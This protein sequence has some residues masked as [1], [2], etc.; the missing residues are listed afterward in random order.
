M[1][2]CSVVL[3][4]AFVLDWSHSKVASSWSSVPRRSDQRMLEGGRRTDV[5]GVGK[6]IEKGGSESRARNTSF[7]SGTRRWGPG[8]WRPGLDMS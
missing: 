1:A 3:L 7:T 6:P 5:E 4:L 8:V 2:D